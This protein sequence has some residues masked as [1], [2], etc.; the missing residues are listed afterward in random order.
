MHNQYNQFHKFKLNWD[1]V[2]PSN[3][4]NIFIYSIIFIDRKKLHKWVHD[5]K[6]V[7]PIVL[8]FFRR[9]LYSLRT[10]K[11]FPWNISEDIFYRMQTFYM[12][13]SWLNYWKAKANKYFLVYCSIAWI[14]EMSIFWNDACQNINILAWNHLDYSLTDVFMV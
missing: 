11:T 2:I 3:R 10:K 12:Q 7:L 1:F 9:F 14:K 8:Y 13:W 4:N 5:M 6:M